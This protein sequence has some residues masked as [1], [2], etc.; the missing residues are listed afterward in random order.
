[1]GVAGVSD[2]ISIKPKPSLGAIKSDIESASH[3]RAAAD[4]KKITVDVHGGDVTLS[5]TG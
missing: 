4:T 2:Q 3:R 1:M 5:G